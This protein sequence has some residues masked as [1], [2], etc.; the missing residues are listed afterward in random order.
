MTRSPALS[1]LLLLAAVSASALDI[2]VEHPVASPARRPAG[3][4][5][6]PIMCEKLCNAWR[7]TASTSIA[8]PVAIQSSA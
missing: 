8:S 1:A 5:A 2:A 6:T 3:G 4:Y 7:Q